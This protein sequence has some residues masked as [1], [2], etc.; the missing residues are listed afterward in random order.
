[1]LGTEDGHTHLVLGPTR[2]GVEPG[3]VVADDGEALDRDV[4]VATP[5]RERRV[6]VGPA[7][8]VGP[9]GGTIADERQVVAVDEL[10]PVVEPVFGRRP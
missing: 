9:E 7:R 10:D 8:T 5:Q 3:R 1:M 4:R 6:G 2:P